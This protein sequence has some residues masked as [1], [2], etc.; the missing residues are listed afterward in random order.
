MSRSNSNNFSRSGLRL[1]LTALD[2][3]LESGSHI[4]ITVCGGASMMWRDNNRLSRD[5]DVVSL[6]MPEELFQAARQVASVYKLPDGWLNDTV[7]KMTSIERPLNIE[8]MFTG[9]RLIVNSVDS[10]TLLAM[11]LIAKR[12]IDIRDAAFLLRELGITTMGAIE[13]IVGN[14]Y[15][16]RFP[17]SSYG[18]TETANQAL[19]AA[20]K[21][22][23]GGNRLR[24]KRLKPLKRTKLPTKIARQ[25]R[26]AQR[27]DR[28]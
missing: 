18:W 11:K 19:E 16:W 24:R 8:P 20:Q 28:K 7:S 17:N 25:Q 14:A 9:K 15:D 13:E 1:Y 21:S 23:R 2:D 3:A 10:K 22:P 5:V 6:L 26:M 27:S 4:T 12:D